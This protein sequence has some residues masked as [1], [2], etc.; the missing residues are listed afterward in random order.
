MTTITQH[1]AD[2]LV[3]LLRRG[4]VVPSSEWTTG[5]GRYTSR[6]ALPPFCSVLEVWQV[7]HAA[8][9]GVRAPKLLRGEVRTAFDRLVKARPR[10]ERVVAVT[11]LRGARR[12]LRL[13]GALPARV[14]PN[15]RVSLGQLSPECTSHEAR[16]ARQWPGQG[17]R[18]G[19]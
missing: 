16:A 6:A 4:G 17:G 12:A 10:V 19:T 1:Q 5:R 15:C 13:R 3:G 7:T 18:W 2:S 14:C 11:D 8:H 9:D